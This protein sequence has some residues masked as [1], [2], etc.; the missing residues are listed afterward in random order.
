M[1]SNKKFH[2]KDIERI[3][4][5]LL[6]YLTS[7]RP[8]VFYKKGVLR[9]FAKF[10]G[11]HLCQK[12]FFNKVAGLRPIKKETLAQVFSCE[13]CKISNN[14]FSYRISLV[15]ASVT[16]YPIIF[17]QRSFFFITELVFRGKRKFY[18]FYCNAIFQD[19]FRLNRALKLKLL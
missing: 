8:E 15:A 9:K 17:G 16:S 3:S 7:S 19:H 2:L 14:T 4:K 5:K 12:L 11:K 10:T 1:V 18:L 13:F 6:T